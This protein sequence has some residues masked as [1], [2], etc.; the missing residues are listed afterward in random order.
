MKYRV[1]GIPSTATPDDPSIFERFGFENPVKGHL[2]VFEGEI[3]DVPKAPKMF[4]PP[5]TI[6]EGEVNGRYLELDTINGEPVKVSS[7]L[8]VEIAGLEQ[9]SDIAA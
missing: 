5:E 7:N 6:V 8:Y 9:V 1:V 4:L 2:A 3:V